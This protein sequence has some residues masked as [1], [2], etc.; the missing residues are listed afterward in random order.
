MNDNNQKSIQSAHEDDEGIS[1]IDFA[2]VAGH[3]RRLL[4]GAP[5]LAGLL[6]LA[7]SFAISPTYTAKTVFMPPQQQQ[8]AAGAALQS[9]GGLANLAGAAGIKTIGDQYVALMQSVTVSNRLIN[10]FGLKG[11][12]EKSTLEDTRR[13]L[14]QN[15]RIDLGKKDGLVSVEVSD[16]SPQRAADIANR[17]VEELRR[18]SSELAITEAQQRRVFFEKQLGQTK[19]KLTLAQQALQNAGVNARTLRVEPKAA[20]EGYANL[21]AQ[22]TASEVRLQ[23]M[24][25][26]FTD[27]APEI[28]MALS[29]LMALRG[30]LTKT[31][32]VDGSGGSDAYVSAY[33]EYK[34]HEALF[35]LFSKQYEMARLDESREGALIQVVDPATPPERKSKPKRSVIAIAATMVTGLA[36]LVFVFARQAWRAGVSGPGNRSRLLEVRQAWRG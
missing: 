32:V 13:E 27:D 20:A 17:Y 29:Q 26:A 18:L 15:V 30:Q 28:K 16:H 6:A 10:A 24:R 3:H 12:Y 25:S 2:I 11:L 22:V 36:L 23:A 5:L 4:I 31:E 21:R 1:L 33:R 34:Y 35:E 14:A 9:L 19:G 8:S 7:A